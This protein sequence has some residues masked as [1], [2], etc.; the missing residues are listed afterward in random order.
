MIPAEWR[1]PASP[2]IDGSLRAPMSV[3]QMAIA[4]EETIMPATTLGV[5]RTRFFKTAPIG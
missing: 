1:C 4:L 5:F 3:R 2:T